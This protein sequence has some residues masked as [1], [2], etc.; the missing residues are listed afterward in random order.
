MGDFWVCDT[1]PY[2]KFFIPVI[3]LFTDDVLY[4]PWYG[5]EEEYKEGV[6]AISIRLIS[7]IVQNNDIA[8]R[9]VNK[10]HKAPA[11]EIIDYVICG[12]GHVQHRKT[13]AQRLRSLF[14]DNS[15][16]AMAYYIKYLNGT[17]TEKQLRDNL[18]GLF[19]EPVE[20]AERLLNCAKRLLYLRIVP[21]KGKNY[22]TPT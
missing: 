4:V 22:F 7:D 6:V 5:K 16:G 3:F 14:S 2:C 9:F 10:Y 12:F 11:D 20:D 15:I 21:R 18:S 13:E 8:G 1:C 19:V 17:I